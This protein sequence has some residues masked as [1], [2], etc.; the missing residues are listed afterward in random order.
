M[1]YM[2]KIY[3]I[4]YDIFIMNENLNR[5]EYDNYIYFAEIMNVNYKILDF[6]RNTEQEENCISNRERITIRL[7]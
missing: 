6:V 1:R 4:S 7:N 5:V 2:K 3:K